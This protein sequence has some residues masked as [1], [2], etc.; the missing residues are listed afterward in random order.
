M[1]NET[2]SQIVNAMKWRYS[3]EV[4]D[5]TKKVTDTD[6]QTILD[7]GRLSPS[8]FGI[9]PWKFLVITDPEVRAKIR[10]AGFGQQKMTDASHLIVI[11]R[12]TDP[13]AIV[14][15]SVSR[16]MKITGKAEADLKPYRDMVSG[17]FV[18]KGAAA[19]A[20]V[21]HQVYIPLGVMIEAASL[22]GIDTGPMEGFDPAKVDEI[23]GLSSKNLKS[24]VMLALGY[25]GADKGATVPKVRRTFE[26][27]V[28]VI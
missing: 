24:T 5:A 17:A 3:V 6:L 7:A 21:A 11:C 22:L 1:T 23:L 25:R 16:N 27:V 26:E 13:E 19:D 2:N 20:W 28:E 15:E 9:E 14:S 18:G 4:F 12:R 8:S 10:A